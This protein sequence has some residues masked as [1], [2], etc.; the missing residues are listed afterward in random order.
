[1]ISRANLDA[2]QDVM[3]DLY[4]DIQPYVH[5][6]WNADWAWHNSNGVKRA[7]R[8]ILDALDEL[9]HWSWGVYRSVAVFDKFVVKFARDWRVSS[10]RSEARFIHKMQETKFARHFPETHLLSINGLHALVQER[11]WMNRD[12]SKPAMMLVADFAA[13]LGIDDMHYDNFGWNSTHLYPVFIDCDFVS[14]RSTRQPL[15]WGQYLRN[16]ENRYEWELAIDK[17]RG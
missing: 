17:W 5:V 15:T 8:H 2:L 9:P 10:L 3:G 12:L 14:R 13:Q 16:K 1:M 11:V 6:G 4:H 7:R